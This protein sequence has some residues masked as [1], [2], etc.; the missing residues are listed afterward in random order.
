M[1]SSNASHQL[2]EWKEAFY[3]PIQVAQ[4]TP[5]N[6]CHLTINVNAFAD[7]LSVRINEW[8]AL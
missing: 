2:Y 4:M 5:C 3:V 1:P 8:N 7:I 6:L